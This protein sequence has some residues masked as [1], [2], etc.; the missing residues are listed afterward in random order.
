MFYPYSTT[1]HFNFEGYGASPSF[2]TED[3]HGIPEC[4]MVA[5]KISFAGSI[6]SGSIN[7]PNRCAAPCG[8]IYGETCVPYDQIEKTAYLKDIPVSKAGS[9]YWVPLGPVYQ[10]FSVPARDLC[11]SGNYNPADGRISCSTWVST[12]NQWIKA[13]LGWWLMDLGGKIG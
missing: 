13:H 3:F 8:G 11:T 12:S 6:F 4:L 10:K 2:T 9:T 7:V 5:P 1:Y